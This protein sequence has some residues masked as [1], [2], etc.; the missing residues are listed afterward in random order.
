MIEADGR[1]VDCPNCGTKNRLARYSFRRIPWCGNCGAPLAESFHIRTARRLYQI[2]YLI[3]VAAGIALFS[4]WRPTITSIDLSNPTPTMPSAPPKDACLG[5]PQPYQG[6]YARYMRY[7]KVAP[8]ALKT[9][10]GSNYFVKINE[11]ASGRPVL[12]LY[13][14]GGSSF[15]IK[16]PRGE[17][18]LK[19]ATGNTWCGDA[20]LFG[21][22]TETNKVDRVFQFDGEHEYTIELIAQRN[23]NLPTKRISREAF[24]VDG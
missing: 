10:S 4:I 19:Y 9:A 3:S 6:L 16:V 21:A 15:E 20:E 18:V 22:S 13:L 8:L 5:R 24:N 12:S 2:R 1:L 11:A 14:Y 23:G 7:P 17:F